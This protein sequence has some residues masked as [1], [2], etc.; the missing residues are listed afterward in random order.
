MREGNRILAIGMFALALAAAPAL[1]NDIESPTAERLT[2]LAP[3]SSVQ[4]VA[5]PQLD[6]AALEAEDIQREANGL[7]P[8]F[9]GCC[10]DCF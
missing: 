2:G 3:A 9:G 8:R 1:A 10:P 7:P 6:L 5:A 4:R